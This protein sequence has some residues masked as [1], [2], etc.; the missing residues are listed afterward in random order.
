MSEYPEDEPGMREP[1]MSMV[2]TISE[3]VS[4]LQEGS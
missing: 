1:S 2:K 4:A 3:R